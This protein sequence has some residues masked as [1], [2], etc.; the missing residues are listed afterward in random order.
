M[1]QEL[2]PAPRGEHAEEILHFFDGMNGE[3]AQ[4]LVAVG[5]GRSTHRLC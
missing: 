5:E 2:W 3:L 4:V 1:R